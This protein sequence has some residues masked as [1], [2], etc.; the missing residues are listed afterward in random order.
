MDEIRTEAPPSRVELFEDRVAVTRHVALPGPGR[1]RIRVP[2]VSPLVNARHL[3]FVQEGVVVEEASVDRWRVLRSEADPEH[4]R[5]LRDRRDALAA[6][7]AEATQSASR[8]SERAVHAGAV[9]DSAIAMLPRLLVDDDPVASLDAVRAVVEA[10]TSA[11]R[12]AHGPRAVLDDAVREHAEVSARL[13]AAESGTSTWKAD[14]V[15][16]VVVASASELVVRYTIPC[17]VWRPSHRAILRSGAGKHRVAWEVGGTAWNA[18][19]E[20]WRGVEL[21]CSTARP[22]ENAEPPILEDD[23]VASRRKDSQVVVSVREEVVNAARVGDA[24]RAT[25]VPG[26]E[27]GGEPRTYTAPHPV[28]LPSDGRPIAVPLEVWEVD[29]HAA[30]IAHPERSAQIA[31][32]TRQVNGG[33]RP[34]L[35]GPVN[36]VR[37][38]PNGVLVAVGRGKVGYVAPGEPFHLGWGSHDAVRVTRKAERSVERTRIT[39]WQTWKFEVALRIANLGSETVVV[40]LRERIPVSEF[41]DV[42]VSAPRATPAPDGGPDADGILTWHI[43]S[44]RG[45]THEIKVEFT[46]EAPS[47]VALPF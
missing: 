5:A 44:D 20:D 26:V 45:G 42:K 1:H 9:V 36:L 27:D 12:G 7:V 39:G 28:D 43:A 33:A 41:A 14:L 30:W 34:L 3:V 47:N 17:A 10:R 23:V 38:L 24:R 4:V 15:V 6:I 16:R 37:E 29:A 8:A 21:V 18:T 32:R 46:V 25:D 19:G 13:A 35:G 40:E 11:Q 22:G 2:D 31:L